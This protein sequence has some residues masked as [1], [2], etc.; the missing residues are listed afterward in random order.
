M[1]IYGVWHLSNRKLG[2]LKIE[3]KPFKKRRKSSEELLHIY[4]KSQDP[5]IEIYTNLWIMCS[6]RITNNKGPEIQKN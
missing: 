6:N 4:C 2:L 5:I 1:R 3:V